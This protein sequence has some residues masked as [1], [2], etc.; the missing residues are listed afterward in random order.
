[1]R[2]L[3]AVSYLLLACLLF[4]LTANCAPTQDDITRE[5]NELTN[6]ILSITKIGPAEMHKLLTKTKELAQAYQ[7]PIDISTLNGELDSLIG[8]YN[9]SK[10]SCNE[11]TFSQVRSLLAS[12]VEMGAL[13]N[14][15]NYVDHARL[16][17]NELCGTE[18]KVTAL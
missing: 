4:V 15:Y 14:L 5:L 3:S 2:C 1:M 13:S 7:G 9:L 17:L 11:E 12:S 6:N 10:G 16:K 18:I 8:I